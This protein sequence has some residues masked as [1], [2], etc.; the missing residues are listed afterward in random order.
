MV[1]VTQQQLFEAIQIYKEKYG[2]TTS[3]DMEVF[4]KIL[5]KLKE[6]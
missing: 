2:K 4:E 6:K 5:K 1:D 3:I